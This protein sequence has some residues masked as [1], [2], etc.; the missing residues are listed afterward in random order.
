MQ[1]ASSSA[2]GPATWQSIHLPLPARH[3]VGYTAY[4]AFSHNNEAC[5]RCIYLLK[6]DPQGLSGKQRQEDKSKQVT[7]KEENI[8]DTKD[9]LEKLEDS[10]MSKVAL[11]RQRRHLKALLKKQHEALATLKV[12]QQDMAGKDHLMLPQC[13]G[14]GISEQVG[15]DKM[16]DELEGKWDQMA[17]K[18]QG[19]RVYFVLE[20]Y[21]Q[22][23]SKP[24]KRPLDTPYAVSSK[25]KKVM[26]EEIGE[27]SVAART[28]RLNMQQGQ[29]GDQQAAES[30]GNKGSQQ[31]K[32]GGKVGAKAKTIMRCDIG[33]MVVEEGQAKLKVV[34][35]VEHTRQRNAQEGGHMTSGEFLVKWDVSQLHDLGPQADLAMRTALG[36]F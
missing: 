11:S 8:K 18:H 24:G 32:S 35:K 34:V 21:S 1:M 23:S 5:Q 27:D 19:K 6:Q 15:I 10:H 29:S 4:Q 25:V 33:I 36:K 16:L 2:A 3:S 28:K 12:K 30:A 22:A 14:H 13:T 31:K 17:Q 20:H 9:K 26:R 7:A